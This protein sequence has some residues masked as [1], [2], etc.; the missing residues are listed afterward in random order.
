[1]NII[2]R[3]LN[4]AEI[5]SKGARRADSFSRNRRAAVAQSGTQAA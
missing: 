2:T 3:K 1:L 5:A 4:A